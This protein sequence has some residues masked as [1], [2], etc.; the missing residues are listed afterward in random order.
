MLNLLHKNF[1]SAILNAFKK[2]KGS[3]RMMSNQIENI[4]NKTEIIKNRQDILERSTKTGK[5]K[6]NHWGS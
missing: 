3:I 6:K 1:E 2:I 4:N 5:E